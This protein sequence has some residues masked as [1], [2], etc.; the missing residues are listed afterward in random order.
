[1]NTMRIFRILGLFFI[2][3]GGVSV[4]NETQAQPG[5]S[6][7]FQTFYNELSPY[8]RWVRNP[9]FGSVWIPDVPRGFQPYSTNGYWEVTEYGNTWVSDYDWGWAPFH[10]GRW[11]FDDYNGWFWIPDYEWGPA[12]V[13]WRSG[14]GYYGWAPLGPGMNVNVSINLPSFWWVFV[15]QRY[16]SYRNWYN[17]CPPR[18][19]VT[20][21]YNQTVII[22]NYYRSNNRTYVYGPRRD[23]IERVTRRSV[24]VRTIDATP[25]GRGRVIVAGNNR[26]DN[27]YDSR[28]DS[29]GARSR[30]DRNGAV[31]DADR[32][33]RG[34]RGNNDYNG[35]ERIG[36]GVDR[37]ERDGN[38]DRNE[39][40]GS[41]DRSDRNGRLNDNSTERRG[42]SRIESTPRIP[43]ED[44]ENMRNSRNRGNAE[45]SAPV[46]NRNN[47]RYEAPRQ[48]ER[49]N[50]ESG[51]PGYS[52]P[53]SERSSRP[54]SAPVNPNPSRGSY[55]APQ[56]ASRPERS[57]PEPRGNGRS[58]G[59]NGG[60]GASERSSRN[61]R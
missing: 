29:R 30:S 50:R 34:S 15:P 58:S 59:E 48:P 44:R 22:N 3:S 12:W 16:V 37:S 42:D 1:M 57:A 52:S 23:E 17:Y 25:N 53:R 60:R 36:G 31:I 41:I 40:N 43:S 54:S 45:P 51:N 49:S 19:R 11:S 26:G 47:N 14:G 35:N 10:Y 21:V 38:T 13:N 5:V 8:G 33:S 20:H 6:I 46:E 24:P 56:R 27:R 32:N 9:Q 55:E 18:R 4:S 61:P 28:D 7:S 39:R 2:L